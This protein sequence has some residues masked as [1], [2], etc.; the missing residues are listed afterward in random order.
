MDIQHEFQETAEITT[1]CIQNIINII[2]SECN[3][4]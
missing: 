2:H 4:Q 1:F 3:D